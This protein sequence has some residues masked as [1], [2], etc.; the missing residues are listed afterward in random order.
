VIALTRTIL[1]IG[2]VEL[3]A[4]DIHFRSLRHSQFGAIAGARPFFAGGKIAL[5]LPCGR[6]TSFSR[7]QLGAI[8]RLHSVVAVGHIPLVVGD[9]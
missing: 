2:C 4:G 6:C 9:G 3:E 8:A 7:G 5:L 1:A